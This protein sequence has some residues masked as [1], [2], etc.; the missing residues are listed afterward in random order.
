MAAIGNNHGAGPH[1]A[2]TALAAMGGTQLPL[3][4]SPTSASPASSAAASSPASTPDYIAEFAAQRA[5]S[6]RIIGGCCGTTPAQI[7]TIRAALDGTAPARVFEADEH[8]LPA[9]T[10]QTHAET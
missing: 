7:E 6:A 2:L 3:R 4:R 1:A 10:T 8:T 5:P 9:A